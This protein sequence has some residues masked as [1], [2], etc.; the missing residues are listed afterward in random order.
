MG[1]KFSYSSPFAWAGI[2]F[3]MFCGSASAEGTW[4]N[5]AKVSSPVSVTLGA[6]Y[7]ATTPNGKLAFGAKPG[8]YTSDQENSVGTYFRGAGAPVVFQFGEKF[9]AY[10]GGIWVPK[11]PGTKPQLYIYGK[12]PPIEYSTFASAL[13]D[14]QNK[15]PASESSGTPAVESGLLVQTIVNQPTR[16][17]PGA[18]GIA[19]GIVGGLMAYADS[20]ETT[21]TPALMPRTEIND[22]AVLR[23]LAE[24][25]QVVGQ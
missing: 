22:E 16:I 2:A 7:S 4:E 9:R 3:Y 19:G 6:A 17:S 18:A 20:R 12:S 5:L 23:A 8:V 11:V 21:S 10:P 24:Q 1:Q 13:E 15:P 25:K 14:V